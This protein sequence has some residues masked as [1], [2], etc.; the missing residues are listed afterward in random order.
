ML[1]MTSQYKKVNV[2]LKWEEKSETKLQEARKQTLSERSGKCCKQEDSCTHVECKQT[3]PLL[4]YHA[5]EH[6]WNQN[7]ILRRKRICQSTT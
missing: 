6:S 5:E 1:P 4:N 7:V 2:S 3:S